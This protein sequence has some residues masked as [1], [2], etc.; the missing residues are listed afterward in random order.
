MA[1]R[2]HIEIETRFGSTIL[3]MAKDS[4]GNVVKTFASG[5]AG[6]DIL[7][8]SNEAY[9]HSLGHPTVTITGTVKAHEEYKGEK[10]TVLTR[11]KLTE[12]VTA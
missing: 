3:I 9:A 11:I 6:W 5:K 2:K 4:A 1:S 7:E 8:I 10:N 12:E